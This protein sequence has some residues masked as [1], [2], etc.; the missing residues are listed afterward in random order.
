M[1]IVFLPS[2]TKNVIHPSTL[3]GPSNKNVIITSNKSVM[4]WVDFF[5]L[6]F[7]VNIDDLGEVFLR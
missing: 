7:I 3:F 1:G 4:F 5:S 2:H 6:H